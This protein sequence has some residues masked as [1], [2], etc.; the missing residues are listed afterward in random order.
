[1][2]Y[3]LLLI[4]TLL[5]ACTKDDDIET[6]FNTVQNE[7]Q[8]DNVNVDLT[9]S[10]NTFNFTPTNRNYNQPHHITRNSP[11]SWI[12][13]HDVM[14]SL[15][16]DLDV[17][18]PDNSSPA[19]A[20]WNGDGYEDFIA[21]VQVTDCW[22]CEGAKPEL[23]LYDPN[24]K[25]FYYEEMKF[26]H[27]SNE[28]LNRNGIKLIGD[29]DLDG[30]PDLLFGGYED[31]NTGN[32]DKVWILENNYSVDG[33]FI[34][35]DL[36]NFIQ[37]NETATVDIDGDGDL[38]IFVIQEN[39]LV[40]QN[41]PVFL[42]NEGNFNF[43]LDESRFEYYD[44]ID[45]LQLTFYHEGENNSIIFEDI[46]NDGYIDILWNNTIDFWADEEPQ[47]V[48]DMLVR[49]NKILWGSDGKYSMDNQT[50]IPSIDGFMMIDEIE[51]WDF[52]N[53]G[54]K[55]IVVV[56]D[57]GS[58]WADAHTGVIGFYIQLLKLDNKEL[59]DI[60]DLIEYNTEVGKTNLAPIRFI[61]FDNDGYLSL[62]N[63]RN[64]YDVQDIYRWEWDGVYIKKHN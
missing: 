34:P 42:I 14:I 29:F 15:G 35:H 44:S 17:I 12:N 56:R 43:T 54:I 2:K 3:K 40:Y 55:E 18:G 45:F 61:D 25:N 64:T 39:D 52:D 41:K 62:S 38:D 8:I 9:T 36:S 24:N 19:F 13:P 50:L 11:I 26:T 27:S 60:T 10:S 58:S 53:D 6:L 30:D 47:E 57:T 59:V 31:H 28:I 4:L 63:V 46:N 1:M 20:D 49:K 33:T 48:K 37:K 32:N 7:I 51:P 5:S 16:R 22:T 23:Y 21:A